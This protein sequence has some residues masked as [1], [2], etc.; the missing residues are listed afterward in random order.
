MFK[1][2]VIAYD[3]RVTQKYIDTIK[4]ILDSHNIDCIILDDDGSANDYPILAVRAHEIYKKEKADG[5]ILL[6]GT[7]IGMNMV[8]NKFKGIRYVLSTSVEE[9]YFSRRHENANCLVFG[10]GCADEAAEDTHEFKLCRRKMGRMLEMFLATKC[11]EQRHF[12]RIGQ[13]EKIENGEKL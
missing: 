12:R 6:C 13:I 5:M 1:K 10:V 3:H 7:G 4:K 11:E 9:A 2:F 8:A